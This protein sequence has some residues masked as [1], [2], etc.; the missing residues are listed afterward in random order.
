MEKETDL[1]VSITP[2][3]PFISVNGKMDSDMVL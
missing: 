3:K 2:I 1:D